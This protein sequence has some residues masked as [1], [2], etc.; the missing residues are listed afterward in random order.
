MNGDA[1]DDFV[2]GLGVIFA[3]AEEIDLH[4]DFGEG[5]GGASWSRVCGV[6]GVEEDGGAFSG[7]GVWGVGVGL[8]EPGGEIARGGIPRRGSELGAEMG[9]KIVNVLEGIGFC[10]G[11]VVR[12]LDIIGMDIHESH[13]VVG[14][15]PG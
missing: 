15:N 3:E 12:E 8:A 11:R 6:I 2:S 5:F 13:A 1:V 10:G 4:A 9:E 14:S 7:E